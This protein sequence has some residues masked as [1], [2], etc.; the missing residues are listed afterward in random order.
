MPEIRIAFRQK[1]ETITDCID[2][3]TWQ[4]LL[5]AD[6]FSL[7]TR[8]TS[9]FGKQVLHQRLRQGAQSDEHKKRQE[10]LQFMMADPNRLKALHAI[11]KHLRLVDT[12]IAEIGRAH[13]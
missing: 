9:I 8:Q 12:E 13:V 2:E 5:V 1:I 6:Y 7:I 4:D 11:C 3:Q 10:R